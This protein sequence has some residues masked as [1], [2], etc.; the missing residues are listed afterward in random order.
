[1]IESRHSRYRRGACPAAGSAMASGDGL[2]SRVRLLGGRL[3]A[4]ELEALADLVDQWALPTLELTNRGNLQVRGLDHAGDAQFTAALVERG[5]AAAPAA[6]EA[7]RN[8]LCTPAAD[9]DPSA[10][11][12]PW[13]V[14]CALDTALASDP[15]LWS[16]PAKFRL[17]VNGGG[18][19]GLHQQTAD[20]RADAVRTRTGL[21]YRLAL[22]GSS[23]AAQVIG[24]CQPSETAAAMLA[25]AR[26]FLQQS[27]ELPEPAT[28]LADVLNRIGCAPFQDLLGALPE[29]PPAP[30][31]ESLPTVL[32][33][34]PGWFGASV[35]FG[36]LTTAAARTLAQLAREAGNG[37]LRVTPWRQVLLPHAGPAVAGPLQALGLITQYEDPRLSVV[38]CPG[39][40]A[41]QSGSTPVRDDALAWAMALP[42]LFDGQLVVHVS[43]CGKGC[44]RPSASPLTLTAR[45]GRYDLILNDRADP[46]QTDN[47]LLNGLTPAR[48][49]PQLQRL[50]E[51]LQQRRRAGESLSSVI[52]RLGAGR[53]RQW[54]QDAPKESGQS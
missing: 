4:G 16:L 36:A 15:A 6:A 44:A 27:R 30:V 49:L 35:P 39:A 48:V 40:P 43:G 7:S 33:A 45:D 3:P 11:A 54:L 46:V 28:R 10:L 20:I 12:D 51:G 50:A 13:S 42:Q 34:Q 22:A 52:E 8:V 5:L 17:L 53:I 23:D 9:L 19:T 24:L 31:P 37:E 14:A 32:G 41:C 25:L 18:V 47:R 21:H 38:A 29:A 26:F 2:L 1:M